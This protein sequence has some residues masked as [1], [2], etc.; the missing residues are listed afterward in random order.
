MRKLPITQEVEIVALRIPRGVV[1]VEVIFSN[2]SELPVIRTPNKHRRELV[3]IDHRER[4]EVSA[5]RPRVITNLTTRR[6]RHFNNLAIRERAQIKL[7]IFI[8][9]RDSFSV[10]R[11]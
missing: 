5:R 8:A 9:E 2:V 4:E 10:G 1:G 11:P 3:L 7:A 6:I